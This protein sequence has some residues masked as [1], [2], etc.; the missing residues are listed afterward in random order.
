MYFLILLYLIP[1]NWVSFAGY[2]WRIIRVNEDGSVRLLYAGS[3]GTDGYINGTTYAYNTNNNH[4]A[5]HNFDVVSILSKDA[6]SV[7]FPKLLSISI[8]FDSNVV[9]KLNVILHV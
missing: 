6:L 8:L 2:L 1:N 5:F 9:S 7:A 4:P 3:G